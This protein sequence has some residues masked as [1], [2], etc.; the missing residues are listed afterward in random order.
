[1]IEGV[2]DTVGHVC[3]RTCAVCVPYALCRVRVLYNVCLYAE[4]ILG[5]YL[6]D[7]LGRAIYGKCRRNALPPSPP[8]PPT[9]AR[10]RARASCSPS[11]TDK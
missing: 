2:G 4:C 7:T 11:P 8:P 5:M 6:A 1:M 10:A 9:S 3:Q